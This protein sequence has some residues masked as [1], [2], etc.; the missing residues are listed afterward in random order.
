MSHTP[1][2]V[3]AVPIANG[4]QFLG[5]GVMFL[6]VKDPALLS[7]HHRGPFRTLRRF[8]DAGLEKEKWL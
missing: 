4:I 5:C 7:V 1:I 8:K 3:L 2:T 6:I